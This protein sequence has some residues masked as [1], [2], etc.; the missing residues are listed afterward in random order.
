M[1]SP[2]MPLELRRRQ[3]LREGYLNGAAARMAR[4]T[5]RSKNKKNTKTKENRL[6][7]RRRG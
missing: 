3:S 2:L 5:V 4:V 1:P 6:G 7:K